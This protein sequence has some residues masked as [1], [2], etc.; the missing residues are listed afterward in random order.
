MTS[1]IVST[2]RDLDDITDAH[3]HDGD[4]P[5][6]CEL[7]TVEDLAERAR[8]VAAERAAADLAADAVWGAR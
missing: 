4:C 8:E 5:D 6:D 3:E 2:S 7:P 1:T